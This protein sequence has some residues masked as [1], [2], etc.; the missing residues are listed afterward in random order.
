[1]KK[2]LKKTYFEKKNHLIIGRFHVNYVD[3]MLIIHVNPIR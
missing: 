3:L 2:N 1:M